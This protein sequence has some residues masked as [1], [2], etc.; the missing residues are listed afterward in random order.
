MFLICTNFFIYFFFYYYIFEY[1]CCSDTIFR[2]LFSFACFINCF[3]F[4]KKCGMNISF[5]I[6][7]KLFVKL[8]VVSFSTSCSFISILSRFSLTT[9]LDF[10]VLS[11][12]SLRFSSSFILSI[13]SLGLLV[14]L[15]LLLFF[16]SLIFLYVFFKK[17]FIMIF[18]YIMKLR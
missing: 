17:S 5:G 16:L 12:S 6:I 18:F 15:F 3:T 4:S 2:T 13:F 9:F 7:D 8:A 10:L 11:F 1:F 14:F